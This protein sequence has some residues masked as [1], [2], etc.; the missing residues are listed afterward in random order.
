[1][2]A[3]IGIECLT[4][5]YG[6]LPIIVIKSVLNNGQYTPTFT[7]IMHE[8][9]RRAKFC[10]DFNAARATFAPG[11]SERRNH[12]GR[13]V[14]LDYSVHPMRDRINILADYR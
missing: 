10:R 14:V 11:M 9:P 1:M 13:A 7:I 3:R 4:G 5:R 2:Y 8:T 12:L 6:I